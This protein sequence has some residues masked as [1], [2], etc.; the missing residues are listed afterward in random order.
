MI[1]M[2]LKMVM[3]IIIYINIKQC[4]YRF[5][6]SGANQLRAFTLPMHVIIVIIIIIVVIVIVIIIVI[7][8]FEPLTVTINITHFLVKW[9]DSVCQ[10]SSA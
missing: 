5:G 3:M 1:M 2:I 4:M 8:L 9:P 6:K 7:N 10:S